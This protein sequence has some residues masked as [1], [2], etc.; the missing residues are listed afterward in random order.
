CHASPEIA[1][2]TGVHLV[3]PL[4]AYGQSVHARA[5]EQGKNAA[6][7]TSCHGSHDI[8]P[9]SSPQSRVN[10]QRVPATCG[11][12]HGEVAK[13]FATSVHGQAAARGVREAPVCTDCHGEHRIL[14]P[15][16]AG[17]PVFATNL[18]KMTCGRCHGDI[19]VTEKFGLAAN[20]VSAFEDSYHGLAGRAGNRTVANCA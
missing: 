3:Q 5:L 8:L 20:A 15:N 11:T 9:A 13:I 12:C 10:H 2:R 1:K 18:P 4:A 6:S 19:R 16:E 14:S 17:S 7:C